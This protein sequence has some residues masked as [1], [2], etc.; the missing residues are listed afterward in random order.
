MF[1]FILWLVS[2]LML[3]FI[4]FIGAV[5][6]SWWWAGLPTL[7]YFIILA[8]IQTNGGDRDY[9]SGFLDGLIISDLID[10]IFDFWNHH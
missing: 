3:V 9:I 8:L 2:T 5:S 1:P 6:F 7:I 4:K 10:A